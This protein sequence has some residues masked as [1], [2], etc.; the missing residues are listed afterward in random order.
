MLWDRR[1]W[2]I[3]HGAAL[4]F[5]H[6]WEAV[7]DARIHAPFALIENHVLL[8]L[9]GDLHEADARMTSRLNDDVL[10]R[11]LAMIPEE[12]LM[13][14]PEGRQPAFASADAN[15][16]AYFTYLSQ[17]LHG[18]RAFRDEAIRARDHANL[19]ASPL[20]YRR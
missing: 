4:Y 11:T 12:L 1:L 5:H 18:P 13:D 3:D 6:N 9:A 19:A 16:E 7:D 14:A 2:L 8:P 20:S 17:R 10:R 15:R